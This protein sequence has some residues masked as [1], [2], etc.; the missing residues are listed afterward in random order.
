MIGFKDRNT[1]V[2]FT[3]I[4]P[5][6]FTRPV[7]RFKIRGEVTIYVQDEPFTERF[8]GAM[9]LIEEKSTPDPMHLG[10]SP[11]YLAVW[12]NVLT[13]H[14]QELQKTCLGVDGV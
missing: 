13:T 2:V 4:V 8:S 7:P 11:L 6:I 5:T 14:F 9:G 10:L 3:K 1:E 12:K